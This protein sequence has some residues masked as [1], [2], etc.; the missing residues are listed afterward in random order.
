MSKVKM[1]RFISNEEIIAKVTET[2]TGIKIEKAAAIM[3]IGEGQL[4]MVPWLPHAKEDTIEIGMDRIMFT[5]EPLAELSNEYSTK[6]GSGLVV[7][8]GPSGVAPM[9]PSL[10]FN[11]GS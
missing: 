3:P 2:K 7:P 9:V 10:K 4:A 1:V 8:G 11:G 6:F 5:F